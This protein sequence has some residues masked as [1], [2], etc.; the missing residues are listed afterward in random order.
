MAVKTAP[1]MATPALT[2]FQSATRSLRA[3][4]TIVG[5]RSLPP[6]SR[7]RSSNQ[8]VRADCS[9][10]RT[11]S[12]L[13]WT[14][15]ALRRGLP[16]LETPCSRSIFPLFQGGAQGPHRRPPGVGCRSVGRGGLAAL[17]QAPASG[18]SRL[19]PQG[20]VRVSTASSAGRR[21]PNQDF[22]RRA[23]RAIA[24]FSTKR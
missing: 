10:C 1:S 21:S 8:S 18:L 14:R 13:S 15:V 16:A 17:A 7:T 20:P 11:Q 6:L 2:Y 23:P 3:R 12:Q 19:K 5:L 22:A 4:A 24:G 9:W